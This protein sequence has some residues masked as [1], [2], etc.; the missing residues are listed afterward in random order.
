MFL[1]VARPHRNRPIIFNLGAVAWK[2]MRPSARAPFIA[3]EER[4]SYLQLRGSAA[5]GWQAKV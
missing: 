2:V 1:D 3:W 4:M 5:T